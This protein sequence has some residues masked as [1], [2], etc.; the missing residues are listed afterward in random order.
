MK[1]GT[2]K[3]IAHNLADS[4]ASG[5]GFMI[6]LYFTR[7]FEEVRF[8]AP[9]ERFAVTLEDKAGKS[10]TDDYKGFGGKRIKARTTAS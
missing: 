1:L 2:L 3:A 6:D 7:I 9:P 8:S 4:V 10:S 5:L